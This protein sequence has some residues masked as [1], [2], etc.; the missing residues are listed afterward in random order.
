M[1]NSTT[2]VQTVTT[3]KIALD[4]M[5]IANILRAHFMAG[6]ATVEFDVSSRGLLRGADIVIVTTENKG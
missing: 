3:T 4:E 5:E 6:D 2:T 1:V